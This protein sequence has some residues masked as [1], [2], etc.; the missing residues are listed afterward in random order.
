MSKVEYND[1]SI[2]GAGQPQQTLFNFF[3]LLISYNFDLAL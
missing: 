2:G 1:I 3:K